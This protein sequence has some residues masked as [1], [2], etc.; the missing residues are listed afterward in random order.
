MANGSVGRH[1]GRTSRRYL[2]RHLKQDRHSKDVLSPNI[3]LCQY[4]LNGGARV[5]GDTA[6]LLA[7][8]ANVD[9]A[10]WKDPYT[11][12]ADWPPERPDFLYV[13]WF[14]QRNLSAIACLSNLAKLSPQDTALSIAQ[15]KLDD[16]LKRLNSRAELSDVFPEDELERDETGLYRQ[17]DEETKHRMRMVIEVRAHSTGLP[18]RSVAAQCSLQLDGLRSEIL[19]TQTYRPIHFHVKATRWLSSALA[20]GATATV[21]FITA[22]EVISLENTVAMALLSLFVFWAIRGIGDPLS[23]LARQVTYN[24]P[25]LNLEET[26]VPANFRIALCIPT[27][28]KSIEEIDEVVNRTASNLIAANDTAVCAVILFDLPD[29]MTP[30]TTEEEAS[31]IRHLESQIR[32][33]QTGPLAIFGRCLYAL[34]RPRKYDPNQG[35]YTG[36]ERKRGKLDAVVR[37]ISGDCSGFDQDAFN[38]LG[39]CKSVTHI[40]CLDDDAI[41]LRDCLHRLAAVAMHPLNKRSSLQG[42]GIFLPES[43]ANIETVT[44]S[45]QW[46]MKPIALGRG[47]RAPERI[48]V[49]QSLNAASLYHGKALIDVASY[50][51]YCLDA[52]PDNAVLSHDTLEGLLLRAIQVPG[53]AVLEDLPPDT[54]GYFDRQ[55]RWIR[56]DWQN[57]PVV[58]SKNFFSRL[59]PSDR[60]R[61]VRLITWQ[62]CTTINNGAF[63]PLLV[64]FTLRQMWAPAIALLA[65]SV[66]VTTA[67]ELLALLI[68]RQDRRLERMAAILGQ[69]PRRISLRIGL[70]P[71]ST[72]TFLE[73]TLLAMW[74][75]CSRRKLLQ[76]RP[77]AFGAASSTTRR[78]TVGS[79]VGA[80]FAVALAAYTEAGP[81]SI[82]II[83][84][85]LFSP[86][87]A[88][89]TKRGPTSKA[90][91]AP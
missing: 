2:N 48:S 34:G 15:G 42:Y 81:I 33:A 72:Y 46:Y 53:A 55:M 39:E 62:S 11:L 12:I 86:L 74:R 28:L 14:L 41:M 61:A 78:L 25:S 56:G 9:Q 18:V 83:S 32:L 64:Y 87:I 16:E 50:Q 44:A 7:R 70:G 59:T 27:V 43:V 21:I 35:L 54:V 6:N 69:L 88:L 29:S 85:G 58:L 36:H 80:A 31:L 40:F 47:D 37:A 4:Y 22:S 68:N 3:A 73:A 66:A 17:L 91:L 49:Y 79:A 13:R 84:L 45:T 10:A 26:G 51:E 1:V 19:E 76:W 60:G 57:I 52:L 24:P 90:A 20:V 30:G 89:T 8:E 38:W 82:A 23:L 5:L 71:L 77:A 67:L 65:S 75:L 63:Y